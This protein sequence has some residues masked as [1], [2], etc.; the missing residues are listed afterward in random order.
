MNVW[1]KASKKVLK[2][3]QGFKPIDRLGVVSGLYTCNLALFRSI[4]GWHEW[5][6]NPAIMEKFTDKELTKVFSA[7]RTLTEGFLELDIITAKDHKAPKTPKPPVKPPIG[8]V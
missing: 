1:A 4:R 7:F 5:L 6:S 3:I 8:V 2:E